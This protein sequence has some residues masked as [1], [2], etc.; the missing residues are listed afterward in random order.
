MGSN[1]LNHN[2][3]RRGALRAS[4][5]VLCSSFL[6]TL[7]NTTYAQAET[8]TLQWPAETQT[9]RPWT[10]WWWH[11]SAVQE[12]EITRLME[13]YEAAGLGGVEIT[14]IYGVRGQE[15]ND[16]LYLS[17]A[18]IA[19][20]QHTTKVA[21]HLNMGVD[22]PAGSGW[23]M[24][25]VGVT[26]ADANSALVVDHKR[27]EGGKTFSHIF[28]AATPQVLIARNSEGKQ[29]DLADL[30]SEGRIDWTAPEGDWKV[31][32]LAYRWSGDSVKR[33]GPGGTGININPFTKHAVSN[34][35][36]FFSGTLNQIPGIRAQFHDSFEYEGDWQP[37][38]LDAFA[39]RR[40]YR[41]EDHLP[42]FVGEGTPD[43]VG[44]IKHDYR[45][46]MADLV[47]EEF[48]QTWVDW[49]HKHGQLARNQS[50]GSPANWLDLY[51]ACDIPEIE[52]FGRLKGG[53]AHFLPLKFASS[54]ANVVGRK[55]VSS[56]TATW[57]DEHFTVTLAQVR[58][59]IDRQILAG[60]NHVFY[61]GTAYSPKDAKWPGW[62]FYASTQLNPQNPIWRDFPV[63]NKYVTRC[64][65]LLQASTHDNDI[66]LYWPL[67]DPWHNPKGYRMN[68]RVHNSHDWFF[69]HPIGDAADL[70]DRQGYA[71][72]YIS[73]IG[74]THCEATPDGTIKTPGGTYATVVVPRAEH[75]PM[76]TLNHLLNLA[77]QGAKVI[78]WGNL[79]ESEPGLAGATPSDDWK[80]AISKA[81]NLASS[82]K[83]IVAEDLLET[84]QRGKVRVESAIKQAGLK[85]LRKQWNGKPLYYLRNSGEQPLDRWVA[86]GEIQGPAVIMDP[87]TGRM[88][89]AESRTGTWGQKQIRLQLA[90]GESVFVYPAD[91]SEGL[92]A[93]PYRNLKVDPILIDG[94]WL[95][96]FL[97]GGPKLPASFE[98]KTP[99]PWTKA[100]KRSGEKFAGTARYSTNFDK[101]ASGN[102]WLLDLGRV[103]GS[104]RVKVNGVEIA[105]LVAPPFQARLDNLR[106]TGN[107]LEIEVTG[108]A[109]NRI[110]DL[111]REKVSWRIFKDIN[112][113][114]I[115]YKKFD[116]S[117]WPV[118]P[119]GL[120]GVVS[121][122]PQ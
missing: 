52:S 29:I 1:T 32:S 67:H 101:P 3:V 114:N 86:C 26:A 87:M 42:A 112:L 80:S 79:P 27:V 15:K 62:L 120:D 9:A 106:S 57:L 6:C 77:E 118:R 18:W 4:L 122:L 43:Y 39:K 88:G 85:Y 49:S 116:A 90:A 54:A 105:Q 33:G 121:L 16:R 2:L 103:L 115:D 93:W 31:Y 66:L 14:C 46:T 65:S 61:H 97:E 75:L 68:V 55:L 17:D 34:F 37:E 22:L 82:Q 50:H 73:D 91:S 71:F 113:V 63:L 25:G 58:E 56:E 12:A 78:F 110:R 23:R 70:L 41:L 5:L 53:D 24:G 13:L 51:A 84:L 47:L 59:I 60:V 64:Q 72:D 45:Q 19:A 48:I 35:L 11:G 104:A 36:N 44:R 98:S 111:D 83:L 10:R 81:K 7:S 74:L 40:G 28:G 109:A 99:V 30:I 8:S 76:D 108:V 119:L 69:G 20:L 92:K 102:T 95:I 96:E 100:P 38:Y 21:K 94:P 117:K 107:R 89:V